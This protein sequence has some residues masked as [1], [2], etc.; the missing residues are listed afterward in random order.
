ML[1]MQRF[2][3]NPVSEAPPARALQRRPANVPAAAGGAQLSIRRWLDMIP[4]PGSGG[5]RRLWLVALLLSP[6]L[7]SIVYFGLIASNRY[8]SEASFVVRTASKPV[9]GSGLAALLQMTG[10]SRSQDDAFSVHE[11]ITSRDAI[12]ALKEKVPLQD[13]YARPEADFVSRFPSIF[14]G[15]TLEEFHRYFQWMVSV[16]YIGTSGIS[17]LRIEAFRPDDAHLVA[18]TLLDMSE[19]LVNRMNARMQSD[20]IKVAVDEVERSQHRLVEAQIAITQF[21]NKE[22]MLDPIGSSVAI[23]ELISRLSQNLA[24][25]QTQMTEL[26]RGAS[27]NPALLSLQRRAE[28]LTQQIERERSRISNATDGLANKV[29]AY[30]R[31]AL[32]REFAQKTL[33]Q[34]NAALDT[35]RLEARRQQLYLERVV[36]PNLP[37]YPTMPRS[38]RSIVTVAAINFLALL[39]GWL[40]YSGIREH[41]GA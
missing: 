10:L 27:Q 11:F 37:D 29:I 39:I 40:I 6:T 13:I 18:S 30:E 23:A 15:D 24:E 19:Q 33:A 20:A 17:V 16:S 1:Q 32:D 21:R 8:V 38:I 41:A 9:G 3:K 34:A 31:L 4:K 26:N 2:F 12:V 7:I 25:T 28:A 35:A 5:R 22:M 36:Q 14:Y